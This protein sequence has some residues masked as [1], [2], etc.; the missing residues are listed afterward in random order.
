[1]RTT[2]AMLGAVAASFW[3]VSAASAATTLTREPDTLRIGERVLID[4]GSCPTGQIRE[5]V[6]VSSR[7]PG[8]AAVGRMS[9]CIPRRR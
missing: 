3:I 4:N 6:G 9:K 8:V 2:L 7:T 1:M 5:V